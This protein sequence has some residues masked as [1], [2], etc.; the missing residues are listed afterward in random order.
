MPLWPM[1]EAVAHTLP[2]DA[3]ALGEDGSVPTENA[4]RVTV[5][6][7][8][9]D[10]S[11]SFSF[12]NTT[13]VALAKAIPNGEHRTLEGQTHEVEAKVLAPALVEFFNT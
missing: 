8:I 13:A 11:A 6:T 12:M 5:P 3:A 4:T 7:L 9:M 10:G 1:W 2:Y